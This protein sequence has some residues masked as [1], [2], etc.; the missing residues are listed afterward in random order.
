MSYRKP[1]QPVEDF[2][3][4]FLVSLFFVLFMGFWIIGALYGLVAVFV[5]AAGLDLCLQYLGRRR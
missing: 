4:P 2:T 1:V 3:N 5:S